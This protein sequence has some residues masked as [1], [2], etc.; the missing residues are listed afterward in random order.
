MSS[1]FLKS[2]SLKFGVAHAGKL[3][4]AKWNWNADVN[5]ETEFEDKVEE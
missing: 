5:L 2:S 1:S 4:E 3:H